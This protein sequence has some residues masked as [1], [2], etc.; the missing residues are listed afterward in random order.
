MILLI[1]PNQ[2]FAKHPGLKLN[3]DRI[4]L[5]EESLF[6]GDQRYPMQFHKQKLWLHRASMKRYESELQ[7]KGYEVQYVDYDAEKPSLVEQLQKSI[8][9]KDRKATEL[10]CVDPT[11]FVLEKRLRK[12]C[13]ILGLRCEILPNSGFLNSAKENQEFRAGKKCVGS[14]LT[15]TSGSVSE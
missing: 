3:P 9:R 11:D 6:F 2:L 10:C 5:L 4:L 13:E 15:S 7:N 8:K 12:A 14:W 1:F